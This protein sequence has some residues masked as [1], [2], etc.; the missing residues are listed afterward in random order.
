MNPAD[1]GTRIFGR[2]MFLQEAAMTLRKPWL[3]GL[4]VLFFVSCVTV[5]IY[6]P[7]AEIQKAA[8]QIVEDVRK[9]PEE[10]PKPDLEQKEEK[11]SLLERFRAI[12]L[13]STE[14]HA[15]VDLNVSTPAV[16]ALKSSI[17]NRYPQLLPLY[18][19]GA[20]GETN[21]GFLAVRDAGGLSLKERADLN[22]LVDQE[23]AD[24]RALYT[25]I[26]KANKLDMGTLGEVQKLFANSWRD[27]SSRGWW[28]QQD[29][30]QWA[31]K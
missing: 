26:I 17:A 23:N 28:I 19:K 24:R 5:N 29:N 30:G 6:F 2:V 27:K 11:K 1:L 31:R 12:R 13:G 14:A 21:T 22:R 16:R 3:F 20:I 25:E 18:G 7:A 10:K 15:A 8:D 4:L 9:A